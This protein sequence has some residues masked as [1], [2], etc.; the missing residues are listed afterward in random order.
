M[1]VRTDNSAQIPL[2]GTSDSQTAFGLQ[3]TAH[4]PGGRGRVR[5]VYEVKPANVPFDGTGLRSGSLVDTGV[6][7]SN[8]SSVQLSELANGLTPG[9]L[10]TWRARV[11]SSSPFFPGTKWL[12]HPGNG[13]TEPDLHTAESVVAV[14]DAQAPRML[15]FTFSP[16]PFAPET[17]TVMTYSLARSGRVRLG[18]YDVQGRQVA[19][20][21]NEVQ[22]A[23]E[24]LLRWMGNDEDGK[25]LAAGVYFVRMN[26][27][28]ITEARKLVVSH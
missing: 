18:V 1:Q 23:G 8:G 3:V 19:K 2:L 24:Y 9:T 4:S 25:R 17:G 14:E 20:L 21:L 7:G 15:E 22:P 13:A 5:L 27:G 6:P 28:K 11:A 12:S 26:F 16:N 10:Y